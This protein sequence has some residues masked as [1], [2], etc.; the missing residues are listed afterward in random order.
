MDTFE[1]YIRCFRCGTSR[2]RHKLLAGI[3]SDGFCVRVLEVSLSVARRHTAWWL[4]RYPSVSGLREDIF[5][6]ASL[7][8]WLA[9]SAFREGRAS[10]HTFAFSRMRTAVRTLLEVGTGTV[11]RHV[12]RCHGAFVGEVLAPFP[13]PLE[14]D[15]PTI[16]AE[17]LI[18]L[19]GTYVRSGHSARD[20]ELLA[21]LELGQTLA[22][23]GGAIGVTRQRAHQIQRAA[24]PLGLVVSAEAV[25]RGQLG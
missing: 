16:I 20:A 13:S 3:C 25:V 1:T 14:T 23:A 9:R 17:A 10:F 2:P 5:Q 6:E 4:R 8:A 19:V 7:A 15:H 12:R 22:E 21:R 18:E 11:T 24:Q